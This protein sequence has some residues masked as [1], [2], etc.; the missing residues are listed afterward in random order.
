MHRGL[1]Q[2]RDEFGRDVDVELFGNLLVQYWSDIVA[3]EVRV[4]RIERDSR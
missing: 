2:R 1:W 3:K 4:V